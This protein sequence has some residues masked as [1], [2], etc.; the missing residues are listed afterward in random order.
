MIIGGCLLVAG[1]AGGF[2]LWG[3]GNNGAYQ[4]G[5]TTTA[6]KSSPVQTIAAGKYWREAAAGYQF[7]MY[8]E[9]DGTLWGV[10][11]G[12]SGQLGNGVAAN[13]SIPSQC[14]TG[15]WKYISCG[16]NFSAGIKADNS[17]WLWGANAVGQLGDNT[18]ASKSSPVQT[19]TG[20]TNWA[21]V[22]C[23]MDHVLAVKT[24]G[25][26]WA[27]GGNSNGH[28]G[29]GTVVNKSSP[30]QTVAG[31]TNWA[32]TMKSVAAG[33]GSS[34]G[35]KTDGTLWSWGYNG[36]G[37]LGD[38]TITSKS[39]PVQT[40]AGGTTW[41]KV[42]R[43]SSYV[44]ATKTDGTLWLWG[45]NYYGGLGD[46]TTAAKSSP[47]QTVAG[48]T[49][50][51]DVGLGYGCAAATKTDGSLWVW[52]YNLAGELGDNTTANK[53]SPVQTVTGGTLWSKPLHSPSSL[54][55]NLF[56]LKRS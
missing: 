49:T 47:V 40:V 53:S 33:S 24:D 25:T 2:T 48:G 50:W 56:Y 44:A 20:G 5:D 23:G 18:V 52:G 8:I 35:I 21:A 22:S 31:G 13:V 41:S 45:V 4:L 17:L 30:V 16:E 34:S 27:W 19:V 51:V 43:N 9:N 54:T 39:S 42:V 32:Q 10:G 6:A 55:N 15:T 37:E 29:D 36:G 14:V 7:A 26:L 1:V 3:S 28:L 46:N 38:N 12:A 11:R